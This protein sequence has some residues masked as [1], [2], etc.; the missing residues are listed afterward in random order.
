MKYCEDYPCC[1]HTPDDPCDYAGPTADDIMANPAK[2]HL[3]CDHEAGY[4]RYEDDE[5]E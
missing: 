3:G 5:E 4:C 1:G 2:Y